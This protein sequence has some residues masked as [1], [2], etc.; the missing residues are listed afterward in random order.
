MRDALLSASAPRRR[1]IS[2]FS[3]TCGTRRRPGRGQIL[4]PI[5]SKT[6]AL[7][8]ELT[9]S[10][11][12]KLN[13]GNSCWP[14]SIITRLNGTWSYILTWYLFSF[15]TLIVCL[16]HH[17]LLRGD[18][19][20]N[21]VFSTRASYASLTEFLRLQIVFTLRSPKDLK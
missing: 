3:C 17:S 12:I 10:T 5:D 18:V 21:L 11:F 6:C 15:S 20:G 2:D 8:T 19:Y 16:F 1:S 7:P 14:A 4:W 13:Y 9:G